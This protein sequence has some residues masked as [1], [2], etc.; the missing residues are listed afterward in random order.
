MAL[1]ERFYI[2]DL[3][4][5]SVASKD[6]I[7][8]HCYP[9]FLGKYSE[10]DEY[11]WNGKFFNEMTGGRHTLKDIMFVHDFRRGVDAIQDRIEDGEIE[12]Y[13][14]RNDKP[15]EDIIAA[16]SGFI[17]SGIRKMR[18]VE[19]YSL[20]FYDCIVDYKLPSGEER[21]FVASSSDDF[22]REFSKYPNDIR[23]NIVISSLEPKAYS[24]FPR[25]NIS[26]IVNHEIFGQE[27]DYYEGRYAIKIEIGR[28]H[29]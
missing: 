19:D 22:Q 2:K 24:N 26:D 23:Y 16:L 18:T 17:A 14:Y 27:H 1:K 20:F 29:V 7:H 3:I 28:A 10:D 21:R 11:V 13:M 25:Y 4:F 8:R 15:T 6:S 5:I 12:V 9:I